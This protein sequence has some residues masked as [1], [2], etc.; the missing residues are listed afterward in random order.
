MT[1]ERHHF[2]I[3]S[4]NTNGKCF[5]LDGTEA[6]HLCRVARLGVGDEVF[7]LDLTGSAHRASIE[8]IE[9]GVV[10]GRIL[11]T[12]ENY[13]ESLPRLHLGTGILKGAN[14]DTVVEKGT[15]L[16]VYSMTP[17]TMKH[18]VKKGF[19]RERFEKIAE[20]ATKQCGRGHVPAIMEPMPFSE[21]CFRLK[22]K[23]AAVADNSVTS[24]P[25]REWLGNQRKEL[26]DI[27][28]TVGPEGGYHEEELKVI[29]KNDLTRVSL[30]PRRLRSETA[31]V[32]L[33]AVCGIHFSDGRPT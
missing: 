16:G 23:C 13:H 1:S 15:E 21:W 6:H 31:A 20:S 33:L 12:R 10:S 19:R 4:R 5:T 25:F 30:G 9:T 27:W 14:M 8:T 3:S 29:T 17:L 28:L 22:S 11:E 7:L 24:I 26:G 18:N 2:V 32:A